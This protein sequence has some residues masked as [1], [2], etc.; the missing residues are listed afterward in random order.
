MKTFTVQPRD[1]VDYEVSFREYFKKFTGDEI[2]TVAVT[3]R[4]LAGGTSDLVLG[5]GV[6]PDYEL[7]GTNPQ[8]CKVWVSG[9]T[10]GNDYVVTALVTT[11]AG[12]AKEVDFK[13]KVRDQ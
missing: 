11:S 2:N 1:I 5:P 9:G 4:N 3:H 8:W 6:L 13:I 7:P 10:A 12:R